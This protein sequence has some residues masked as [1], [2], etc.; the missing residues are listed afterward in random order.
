MKLLFLRFFFVDGKI[1]IKPVR[2][3]H[4]FLNETVPHIVALPVFKEKQRMRKPSAEFWNG[5]K[6]TEFRIFQYPVIDPKAWYTY[7]KNGDGKVKRVTLQK[8]LEKGGE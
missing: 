5:V 8:F 1:P 6:I 3:E 2:L 7:K 4:A